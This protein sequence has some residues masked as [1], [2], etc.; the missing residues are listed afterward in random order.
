V[1]RFLVG[2]ITSLSL[3]LRP[4]ILPGLLSLILLCLSICRVHTWNTPFVLIDTIRR[5]AGCEKFERAKVLSGTGFEGSVSKDTETDSK[6]INRTGVGFL[7]SATF[8][9]CATK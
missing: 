8:N 4:L 5:A 3:L 6:E 9:Q 1:L 7:R 2:P